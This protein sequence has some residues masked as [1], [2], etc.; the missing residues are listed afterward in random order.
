MPLWQDWNFW[1]SLTTAVIAVIALSL[2]VVQI[3][4]SNKQ[5]LFDKRLENYIIIEGLIQLYK[6]NSHL[7][8]REN[9][10]I[11]DI[12]LEFGWMTNNSYFEEI[13]TVTDDPL[14]SPYHKQFLKKLED[15]KAVSIQAKLLYHGAIAEVL[16]DFVYRYQEL[17]FSMYQYL[18]LLT[19]IQEA[20]KKW[21]W[22]QEEA[23]KKM[24]EAKQREKLFSA[25]DNLKQAY[26]KLQKANIERAIKKQI[27]LK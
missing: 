22:S 15:I 2:T 12:E 3:K 25:I 20:S 5:H 19:R 24:E 13:A 6:N 26:C 9:E 8:D 1:L 7:F 17:L 27:R 14:K 4:I 21:N 18:I 23:F 16:S 10:P 11:F